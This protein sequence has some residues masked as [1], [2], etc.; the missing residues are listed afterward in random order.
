MLLAD[1]ERVRGPSATYDVERVVGHG[2]FGAVYFAKD[3]A[4]VGRNV[5][6]KEFFAPRHPREQ[7]MLKDLW[8]R[9]RVVGVQASPHPLMP[10]FYE[11]FQFDGHYY[12][13]QEFIEGHTL[14]EI[15]RTRNPLPREWC[16]KWTVCLCDALAFLHSRGI[17]HHDLK[18]ANIRITPHGHLALLDFGAAQYFGKE[19]AHAKQTE[20]YGTEGYLPPELDA[21]N[22]WVAD[23]RTDIFAL[24]CVIYEMLTGQP[25][26]QELIN[27]RSMNLTGDLMQKPNADFDLVNLLVRALSYDKAYRFAS[28]NEFLLEVRKT[29]PPVLLVNT[30][31]IRFG[32]VI[33]G[34]H[35]PPIPLTVYNAGGGELRG[36][37]KPRAPWVQVPVST[38]KGNKRDI[39]VII[40]ASKVP[41]REKL[42]T[43]K[44]EVNCPDVLDELG[45]VKYKG[46]R[47][48]VD[49][50]VR[51]VLH[52]GVLEVVE[53][54]NNNLPPLPMKAL[55]GQVAATTFQL[56]NI[57]ERSTEFK[58]DVARS[59]QTVLGTTSDV[60]FAPGGGSLSPG[61]TITIN[62]TVPTDKLVTGVFKAA[63]NVKTS[64]S[65]QIPVP[66]SIQV[67]TPMDFIKSKFTGGRA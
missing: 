30:K 52:S 17:I 65:Q 29:A 3:P 25:P 55:K 43:A 41:D 40:N 5:A 8:E 39:N 44:L 33:L 32:D 35:V 64:G 42:M 57:G 19:H 61:E 15:I 18:P 47:W 60:S 2:A 34:Q 16:L 51:I 24:G 26:D 45:R 36:E 66:F 11:A 56:K 49:C 63:L 53:R 7:G 62:V 20:L 12:I 6:L 37:I 10:T 28:A 58:I 13:A 67:Q 21:D 38:F 23:V 59:G 9:E 46:D 48:L 22:N 14:D 1:G 50:S 27:A 4:K 54:P 31:H